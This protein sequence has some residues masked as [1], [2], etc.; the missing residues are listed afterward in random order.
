MISS[1]YA[2][3]VAALL[4]FALVPTVANVYGGPDEPAAGTLDVK[5]PKQL[6]GFS[7]PRPG[8]RQ[9]AWVESQFG[10]RDFITRRYGR[11]R[12]FAVRTYDAKRLFHA[13]WNALSYGKQLVAARADD[14]ATNVP[15]QALE[16]RSA[17]GQVQLA[18]YVLLY[19]D[20]PVANP[21][22]FMV[23]ETPQLFL[24]RREPTT[25]VYVQGEAPAENRAQLDQDLRRLL[26]GAC[27]GF[28]K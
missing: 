18:F 6:E 8:S 7:A 16:F 24:G 4:L 11:Y 19:G 15:I 26:A 17:G 14:L 27:G 28:L 2:W 25:L 12:L 22:A 3:A 20:R 5:V 23:G 13:P 10:G 21:I 9:A 1:R